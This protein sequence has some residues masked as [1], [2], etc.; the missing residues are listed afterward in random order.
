[1]RSPSHVRPGRAGAGWWVPR[2]LIALVL[3]AA[4]GVAL[5]VVRAGGIEPWFAAHRLPP[6]YLP[7]G[8]TVAVAGRDIYLDCRGSGTPTVVLDSGLGTGAGGWGFVLDDV[9]A[10][11]RT[12]TWDRPGIGR[13]EPIGRHT[14]ATTAAVLREA[15]AQAGE[16]APFVVVGHS[17]GGVYARL[18]AARQ[19]SEVAGVV[20]V[21]P[22]LPDIRAIDEVAVDRRLV[23]AFDANIAATGEAIAAT[24]QLDWAASLAELRTASIKGLPLELL[25]VDQHYRWDASFDPWEEQ[26]IAAWRRL[27]R[28]LSTDQRLTIAEDSR[29]EIQVDRPELVVGAIRRLVERARTGSGS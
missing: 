8:R 16:R 23:E 14:A 24:E 7:Q 11:A 17:L 21:D 6:P 15:L 1:V 9:A 3:G 28:G 2:L 20:L 13:S 22:F 19:R 18:F 27:L 29:H 25:F 10:F 12:C 4:L 26:L 5:D